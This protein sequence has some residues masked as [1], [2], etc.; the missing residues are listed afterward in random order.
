MLKTHEQFTNKNI[1]YE[2][3]NQYVKQNLHKA[4][5]ILVKL[6][7]DCCFKRRKNTFCQVLEH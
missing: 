2:N 1:R 7:C 6:L 3:L 5:V 4:L